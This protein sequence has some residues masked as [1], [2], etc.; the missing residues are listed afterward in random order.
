MCQILQMLEEAVVPLEHFRQRTVEQVN[1]VFARQLAD[2]ILHCLYDT[3]TERI[4]A[5]MLVELP[6]A[7]HLMPQGD[8][9][10]CAVEQIVEIFMLFVTKEML[11]TTLLR[12]MEQIAEVPVPPDPIEEDIKVAAPHER[13]QQRTVEQ[14][15]D[16]YVPCFIAEILVKKDIGACSGTVRQRA[17]PTSPRAEK[18]DHDVCATRTCTRTDC[19]AGSRR[20]RAR[21]SRRDAGTCCLHSTET[22]LGKK[23]QSLVHLLPWEQL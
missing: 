9:R 18:I 16:V 7:T 11:A 6:A 17:C 10:Q 19:C 2:Q 4:C 12:M 1:D 21:A 5:R 22:H 20:F 13:A 23:W 3:A 14:V 8:V 15:V